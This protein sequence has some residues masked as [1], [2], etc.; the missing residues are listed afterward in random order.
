MTE[1][2]S[3]DP[4]TPRIDTPSIPEPDARHLVFLGF[5]A[6]LVVACVVKWVKA[7]KRSP[8][9]TGPAAPTKK[10][11]P[12]HQVRPRSSRLRFPGQSSW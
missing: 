9:I 12:V 2:I 3:V 10:P 8:D 6:F 4:I 7:G 5:I 1:T 11:E